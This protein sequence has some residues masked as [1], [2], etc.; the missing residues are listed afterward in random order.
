[1]DN[2]TM[3]SEKNTLRPPLGRSEWI[4]AATAA[5]A[6]KGADGVRVEVLAKGFGVTKGSFYWHF[7]DRKDL[8][9]AVLARWKE[10]RIGDIDRQSKAIAGHERDQLRQIIRLYGASRNRRGIAIE[11]AVRDWARRDAQVAAVVATVDQYRLAGA[12]R[13][14]K[15]CGFSDA[16]AKSR[17]L[18][19]YAYVFGQSLMAEEN[20]DAQAPELRQWIIEHIVA[21]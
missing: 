16:E 10:G 17:S 14:F 8:V 13:L 4:D 15:H 2:P 20:S 12:T 18:L 9:D 6:A 1:M 21:N 3:K 7:K 11:L 5:L 19:L